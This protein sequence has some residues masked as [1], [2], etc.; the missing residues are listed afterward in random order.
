[1]GVLPFGYGTSAGIVR[2]ENED[3]LCVRPD[4]GLWAVA[5]GMGG[6]KG[7]ETASRITVEQLAE[8]AAA[9]KPLAESISG[10][11]HQIAALAR[12]DS[13]YESMGSTVV[14]VKTDGKAYEVA[15]VGDSRAYLWNGLE[16][17]RLTRD[18]SYIQ[19]L[20]DSGVISEADALEHPERHVI[21]QALGAE[22]IEAV[23]VDV[24]HGVFRENEKILLCSDGLTNE[25]G[26]SQISSIL[27]QPFSEQVLVDRLIEAARENGG[28]DNISAI[29]IAADSA[30][31]Q[32]KAG[33][34]NPGNP[35]G[36]SPPVILRPG[37][38]ETN[39]S[40][41]L[42]MVIVFLVLFLSVMFVYDIL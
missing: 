13:A 22:E 24:V 8:D 10:I 9:G 42:M 27:R 16:L 36:G 33:G 40:F 29:L 26:E 6:Y 38:V 39:Y 25:V 41:W 18:H 5:D 34:K 28:S 31:L 2:Q 35:S 1:M 23:D 4:I 37:A 12:A 21:L 19:Y 15:W 14:A 30:A 20:I 11:H 3:S 17:T 7:G 32:G